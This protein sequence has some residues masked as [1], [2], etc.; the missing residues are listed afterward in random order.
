M[1][2]P[3][4]LLLREQAFFRI[5]Y[6]GLAA[7][8][9]SMASAIGLSYIIDPLHALASKGAVASATQFFVL[10]YHSGK[11]E[12]GRPMLG[13]KFS[14]I[15]PLLAFSTYQFGFNFVNYFSRN[16]DDILV[17]RYMGAITLGIYNKAYQLMKLPLTILTFAMTPAIQPVIRKHAKEPDKVERVHR[18]FTFKLSLMGSAVALVIILLA[19]EIVLVMLG[20]QWDGVIPVIRILAI[21]VPVQVV[22]ST[23]GSFFQAMNRVDILFGSGVLGAITMV[24]AIVA[25]IVLR[26]INALCWFLVLAFHINFVQAYYFMYKKVFKVP[27]RKFLVIMLPAAAMVGAMIGYLTLYVGK[28]A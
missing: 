12:F 26:D 21:A 10:W 24:S 28:A 13:K 11:T 22:L 18:D 20:N 27:F 3:N 9:A 14:A 25:G 15:K 17:G 1:I 8:I 16:L 6:A 2:V 5:G 23:S 19:K 7:S 4:A